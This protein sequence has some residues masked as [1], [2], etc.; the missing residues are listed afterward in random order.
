MGGKN[1][2]SRATDRGSVG[3]TERTQKSSHKYYCR[4]FEVSL[5][6]SLLIARHLSIHGYMQP[7][8]ILVL[9]CKREALVSR[10]TVA[11]TPSTQLTALAT[12]SLHLLA[13]QVANSSS[14]TSASVA[15]KLSCRTTAV[16]I[17]RSTPR[18]PNA[19]AN[20]Y[21]PL[22]P[23]SAP[24]ALIV[25]TYRIRA[26]L[27]SR[28]R[29]LHRCSSS[30]LHHPVSIRKPMKYKSHADDGILHFDSSVTSVGICG[31]DDFGVDY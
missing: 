15:N 18:P 24:R 13:P 25:V 12:Q 7:P 30:V 3:M 11:V 19:Q 23:R 31:D 17:R 20:T 8:T 6:Y 16:L 5:T 9:Q 2:G 27:P 29:R 28:W 26:R 1:H 14:A 10:H 4:S 22:D 21:T